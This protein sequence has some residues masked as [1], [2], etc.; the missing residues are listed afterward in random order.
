[1]DD[2]AHCGGIL[3]SRYYLFD[4]LTSHPDIFRLS[5][6]LLRYQGI[7]TG[8]LA[9]LGRRYSLPGNTNLDITI[10]PTNFERYAKLNSLRGLLDD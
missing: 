2:L 1:M 9:W 7:S 10:L 3:R 6:P 4:S 5:F 8:K